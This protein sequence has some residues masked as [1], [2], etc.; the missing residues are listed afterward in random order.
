MRKEV[1]EVAV[2]TTSKLIQ[3]HLWLLLITKQWGCLETPQTGTHGALDG[4]KRCQILGVGHKLVLFHTSVL[5]GSR[6]KNCEKGSS[7][8]PLFCPQN[9]QPGHRAQH[10]FHGPLYHQDL[11]P[12]T[13]G[14]KAAT[15]VSSAQVRGQD[16]R[17]HTQPAHALTTAL[18]LISYSTSQ[19]HVKVLRKCTKKV[20]KKSNRS[21]SMRLREHQ[22]ST[23]CSTRQT[24]GC[25]SIQK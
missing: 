9:F 12:G 2:V 1:C 25:V 15:Q 16:R 21:W 24:W 7:D 14:M 20:M 3:A 13:G 8:Q 17:G 10:M 5:A 19:W 6:C 23:P 22:A 11:R 18:S 4:T